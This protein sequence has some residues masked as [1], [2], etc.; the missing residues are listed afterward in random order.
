[1]TEPDSLRSRGHISQRQ[2]Q[3]DFHGQESIQKEKVSF[4]IDEE[5]VPRRSEKTTGKE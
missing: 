3:E 1:M 4:E 2:F 5:E